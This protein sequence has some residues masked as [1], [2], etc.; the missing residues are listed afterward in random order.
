M[1]KTYKKYASITYGH[2]RFIESF[3]FMNNS[4][5]TMLKTVKNEHIVLTR[6]VFGDKWHFVEKRA[7]L[8]EAF[9]KMV[10]MTNK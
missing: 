4:L 5:V 10:V 8:Y 3:N 2:M 6:K 1:A 9:K 7:C